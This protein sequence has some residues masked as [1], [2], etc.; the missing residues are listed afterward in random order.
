MT[1][2]GE[3]L[4]ANPEEKALL[5]QLG[6]LALKSTATPGKASVTIR[7]ERPDTGEAGEKHITLDLHAQTVT[8]I[9]RWGGVVTAHR[10]LTLVI[11]PTDSPPIPPPDPGEVEAHHLR[12]PFHAADLHPDEALHEWAMQRASEDVARV[13][14]LPHRIRGFG[15]TFQEIVTLPR[16]CAAGVH[17]AAG[18]TAAAMALRQGIERVLVQ[19]WEEHEPGEGLAWIIE[20]DWAVERPFQR[21][22]GFVARWMGVWTRCGRRVTTLAPALSLGI[23][24]TLAPPQIRMSQGE[25]PASH[26]IPPTAERVAEMVGREWEQRLGR[27]ESIDGV[28]VSVFRD[29][30]FETW[31]L[32]GDLD[33]GLDDLIRCI[34]Q[35]GNTPTAIATVRMDVLEVE[36]DMHRALVTEAEV[37]SY[38]YAR[39]LLLQMNADN[40]VTGVK[41]AGRD[42]GETTDGWLGVEPV[43]EMGLFA[44]GAADA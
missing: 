29:R 6:E 12:L 31:R 2:F 22:P 11:E 36:T 14:V 9:E 19:G 15:E 5:A 3:F 38:R 24:S 33:T 44:K 13:S 10:T 21:R 20:G 30:N 39:A 34:C 42:I 41:L 35:Y 43:V 17:E 32:T 8:L 7:A 25:L 16:A 26:V 27:G 18:A 40:D 4:I 23:P 37:G 28:I 1:D